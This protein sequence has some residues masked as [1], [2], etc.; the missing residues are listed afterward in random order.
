MTN[1]LTYKETFGE[2]GGL[3]VYQNDKYLVYFDNEDKVVR[4]KPVKDEY[5]RIGETEG[6]FDIR[7]PG[8]KS[9]LAMTIPTAL[10]EKYSYAF[11]L[12]EEVK[13]LKPSLIHW[14]GSNS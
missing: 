13:L 9:M 5:P 1:T 4:F 10:K 11:D 7:I 3:V 14:E 6:I 2:N 8:M 12:M